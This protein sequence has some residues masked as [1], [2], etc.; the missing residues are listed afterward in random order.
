ML[1][2]EHH[3][4]FESIR[5]IPLSDANSEEL[6]IESDAGERGGDRF[7]SYLHVLNLTFGRFEELV[8]VPTKMHVISHAET[9][10]QTL[11][12]PKTRARFGEEF[13][14][15][16]IVYAAE[17]LWFPTPEVSGPC[18]PRGYGLERSS[19]IQGWYRP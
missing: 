12:V 10:T 2:T 8:T 4:Q 18:Y 9:W 15:V 7:G 5:L 11:D 17:H 14:F 16:K 19:P 1:D 13:C 3:N 6:V